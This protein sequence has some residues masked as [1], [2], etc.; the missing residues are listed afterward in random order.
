M[1][2]FASLAETDPGLNADPNLSRIGK[3]LTVLENK[4][5]FACEAYNDAVMIYNVR[6]EV[7]PA[8]IVASTVRVRCGGTL[9]SQ[10]DGRLE[11][12]ADMIPLSPSVLV[13]AEQAA[14]AN[15]VPI[16]TEIVADGLISTFA[17]IGGDAPSFLLESRSK[18]IRFGLVFVFLALVLES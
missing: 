18:L 7:F 14:T 12:F 11:G 6:R 13:F 17:K 3:E 4:I 2:F 15:V 16:W 10:N 5:S 9:P 8:N 1:E